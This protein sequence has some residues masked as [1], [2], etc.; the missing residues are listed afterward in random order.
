MVPAAVPA[1][2]AIETAGL[3]VPAAG[4]VNLTV[5][6]AVV[7]NA[8]TP[9]GKLKPAEAAVKAAVATVAVAGA[10]VTAGTSASAKVAGVESSLPPQ[11]TSAASAVKVNASL[12]EVEPKIEK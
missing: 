11:A 3:V 7:P 5:V 8:G 1:P 6:A 2:E 12:M 10:M 9:A 4:A